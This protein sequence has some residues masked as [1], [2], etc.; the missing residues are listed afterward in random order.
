MSNR[1]SIVCHTLNLATTA[2]INVNALGYLGGATA[3]KGYGPGSVY[4]SNNPGSGASHG[5]FGGNSRDAILYGDPLAPLHPGSGGAGSSWRVGGN[6]GGAVRIAATASVNINGTITA[7]GG[8][9]GIRSGAG[10][11]GSVYI[12][13]ETIS[14]N[15]LVSAAGGESDY[16]DNGSGGGG[17]RIAV[18][19]NTGAQ[20]LLPVPE[21]RF[22]A[23]GGTIISAATPGTICFPDSRMFATD[24]IQHRGEVM[25]P[26][27][28]QLWERDTLIISNGWL[29]FAQNGFNLVVTNNLTLIGN[30]TIASEKKEHYRSAGRLDLFAAELSVGGNLTVTNGASIYVYPGEDVSNLAINGDLNLNLNSIFTYHA[31]PTNG[32]NDTNN[33]GLLTVSGKLELSN[34]SWLYPVSDWTNGASIF[35]EADSLI[36]NATA[37]INANACGYGNDKSDTYKSTNYGPGRGGYSYGGAGYGGRGGSSIGGAPYGSVE[38]PNQP[39]SAGADEAASGG[40]GG[41][42]IHLTVTQGATINGTITANG[43]SGLLNNTNR[44]SGSGSG[45]GIYLS[46]NW[47][48]GSGGVV[49]A[50]GGKAANSSSSTRSGGGGG[51]RIAVIYDTVAQDAL[52]LPD[53]SFSAKG[54]RATYIPMYNRD[55]MDGDLGTLYFPDSRLLRNP[56]N[57]SGVWMAPGFD[58]NWVVDNLLVEDHWLRLPSSGQRVEATESVTIAAGGRLDLVNGELISNSPLIIT[59]RGTLT[60]FAD[61][62]NGPAPYLKVESNLSISSNSFLNVYAAPTNGIAE[63][64]ATVDISGALTLDNASWVWPFSNTTNSGSPRFYIGSLNITD[65][66]SGFNAAARGCSGGP[67]ASGSKGFGAGGGT[68]VGGGAYGGDGGIYAS[69]TSGKAYGSLTHP[70]DPG[71]GG[72][73]TTA[74]TSPGGHGGGLIWVYSQGR[75]IIDGTLNANGGNALGTYAGGGSGGGIYL[76]STGLYGSGTLTVKGGNGGSHSSNGGGSG[77]GG[78]IALWARANHSNFTT[79]IVA[80]TAVIAS[81]VGNEGTYYFGTL[82]VL[83]TVLLL[84]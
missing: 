13:C 19:Y 49:S 66:T 31:T 7:N 81:R 5:G 71:S 52:P 72:A 12:T 51:G 32:V 44:R 78:R 64:G 28:P 83:G 16:G 40:N 69:G 67:A 11:G 14:G 43:E 24:V 26:D 53:I 63:C 8:N 84:R 58:H 37:G 70:T 74:G 23:H 79:N 55:D 75:A 17:G 34:N 62:P 61:A 45:G 80:G 22:W 56:V 39:G 3:T 4:G 68:T 82:P 54:G 50:D 73:G 76:R 35:M 42:L 2:S 60:L 9:G 15:G 33:G 41:G 57:H 77:A 29:R 38:H 36:V 25:T 65:P 1:I 30:N 59:N 21:L 46:C 6:G 27:T 18:F 47:L 20:T 10:S 48:A